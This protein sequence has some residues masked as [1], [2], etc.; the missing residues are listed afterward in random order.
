MLHGRSGTRFRYQ[1]AASIDL[2]Q[3]PAKPLPAV[4]S[5]AITVAAALVASAERIDLATGEVQS[6]LS[7]WGNQSYR[8]DSQSRQFVDRR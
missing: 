8:D 1:N 2:T 6:L 3:E 5:A 4:E 7:Q